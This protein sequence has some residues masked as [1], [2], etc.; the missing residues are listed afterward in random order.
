MQVKVKVWTV[1]TQVA[2]HLDA[3]AR[4]DRWLIMLDADWSHP[5]DALPRLIAAS[6]GAGKRRSA[7]SSR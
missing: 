6:A 5:P 4:D 3:I 7:R 2:E 1:F